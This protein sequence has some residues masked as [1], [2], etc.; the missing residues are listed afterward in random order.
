MAKL[1]IG[2]IGAGAISRS[3]CHGVNSHPDAEMVAIADIN[4]K[5]RNAV[6][7][8]YGIAKGYA[9]VKEILADDELDAVC[10]GLPNYLHAPTAIAAFEAGKHVLLDKPFA[11]NIDE[12][13]AVVAASK[14]AGKVFTVGMNQRFP[15]N[16]QT[17]RA[18]VKRGD[19]GKIYHA[20]AFWRRRA[21]APKFGTWFGDKRQAGGGCLLDIG[22]HL[23]DLCL[24]TMDNFEP[25]SA[26]GAVYTK[27]GNRG[28]GEGG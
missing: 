21:G 2:M 18:L 1:K 8:E 12:A 27:F 7:K 5:R 3:H 22:V 28:L 19:I 14:K 23:L 13:K 11:L 15:A 6:K 25:V 17:V 10:I 20:R 24:F 4:A 26:S 16:A 9:S